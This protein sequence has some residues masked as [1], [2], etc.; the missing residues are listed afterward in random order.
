MS[1]V[2]KMFYHGHLAQTPSR[3]RTEMGIRELR[4]GGAAMEQGP[5]KKRHNVSFANSYS[6]EVRKIT[7]G[8]VLM[9][10][11]TKNAHLL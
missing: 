1:K 3:D 9:P 8:D 11:R 7:Q 4:D 2:S 5:A 10:S 6:A